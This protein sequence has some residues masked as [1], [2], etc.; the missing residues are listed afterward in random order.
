MYVLL[1]KSVYHKANVHCSVRKK[2][3]GLGQAPYTGSWLPSRRDSALLPLPNHVTMCP[4][5]MRRLPSSGSVP[6]L[7]NLCINSEAALRGR[8]CPL[9]E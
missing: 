9:L 8:P 6:T 1:M 2:K 3:D 7:F 5:R 4:V